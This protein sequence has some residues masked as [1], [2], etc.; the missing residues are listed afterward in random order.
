M[1]NIQ[2][3]NDYLELTKQLKESYEL[4]EKKNKDLEDE[5]DD[6]KKSLMTIYGLIHT[7][8]DYNNNYILGTTD[9]KQEFNF[10]LNTCV[11][12]INGVIDVS[13]L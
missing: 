5:I 6:L 4:Y 1:S 7:L 10:L 3:E 2:N 12:F 11:G 13:I 9:G 8:D